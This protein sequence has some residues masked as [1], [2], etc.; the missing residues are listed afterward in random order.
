MFSLEI[1]I[2]GRYWIFYVKEK[3]NKKKKFYFEIVLNRK[4]YIIKLSLNKY[5]YGDFLNS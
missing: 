3:K 2:S 4:S 5:V 1:D